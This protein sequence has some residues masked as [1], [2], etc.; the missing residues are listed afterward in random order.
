M[1]MTDINAMKAESRPSAP[2]SMLMK[3]PDELAPYSNI[4]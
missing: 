2:Q 1:T 3:S 4:M